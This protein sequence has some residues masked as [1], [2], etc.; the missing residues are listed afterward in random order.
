MDAK[1]FSTYYGANIK[2]ATN[3]YSWFH[4]SIKDFSLEDI[5]QL[6]ALLQS[7]YSPL[8]LILFLSPI[9]L[10]NICNKNVLPNDFRNFESAAKCATPCRVIMCWPLH[11]VRF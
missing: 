7:N 9:L 8:H 2:H 6:T 3:A 10:S 5:H 4:T 11:L 1:K